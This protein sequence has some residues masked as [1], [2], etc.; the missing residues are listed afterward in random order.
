MRLDAA[1]QLLQHSGRDPLPGEAG[2]AAWLQGLIDALVDLSSRD[3]LTGLPNRRAFELAI[4][5]EIDRVARS[6]EPALLLT[7]DIDDFK[8]TNDAYGHTAGDLVIQTVGRALAETVRPMD[9]VA[10]MGGEEFSIVLP[11]CAAALGPQVAERIR[12]RVE[13]EVVTVAP[14]QTVG[15][16]ISIGGA[17]A[18]QWVRTTPRIWMDRADVQLYRAKSEGRNR[19][20]LEEAAVSLVSADEKGLLFATSQ[21]QAQP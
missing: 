17:F 11:N 21:L 6:G 8:R 13:R 3:A 16:T 15:V 20:C 2:S 18:P 12:D 19:C 5:R 4:A 10:R 14:G 9:L 7:L 1:L